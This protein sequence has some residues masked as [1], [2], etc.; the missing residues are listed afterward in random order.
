LFYEFVPFVP[1]VT[2]PK[3]VKICRNPFN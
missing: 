2:H 1:I 3:F